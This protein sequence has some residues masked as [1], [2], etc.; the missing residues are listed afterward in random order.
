MPVTLTESAAVLEA[1]GTGKPGRM[2]IRLIDAGKGSSGVYPADTLKAAAE[3]KVFAAGTHMYL[4]HPSESEMYDRPERSVKDLAGV[5]TEDA[6]WDDTAQA[7]VAEARVFPAWRD[8]LTAMAEDIGVSIRALAETKAGQWDGKPAQVVSR[9]TEALSVDFVTHA[10]RGG[11]VMQI[12]ESARANAAQTGPVAVE[13]TANDRREQLSALVKDA[14]S[15]D[16]TWVW[17][18]DFDDT[19]VWFEVESP[20]GLGIYQQTFTVTDDAATALTGDRV[21]VRVKTTYEPVQA[22][23]STGAPT[24]DPVVDTPAPVDESTTLAATSGTDPTPNVPV[25]PAGQSTITQESQ[26][27]D[28]PQ[29]EEARLRQL[30]ADAGRV[31]ALESERDAAA[32]KAEEAEQRALQAEAATYAR[33]FARNLVTK[34][35]SDLAEASVARIVRDATSQALPLTEAGRLDTDAFTPVV[36]K[37]RAEEETYLAAVA[38]ASGIG[39]VRGVGPTLT[40]ESKD[41]TDDELREALAKL[42]EG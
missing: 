30:E 25:D 1:A 39:S 33:D 34:A 11:K 23:E 9:I 29:I 42:K 28:M 7:L 3:A 16:K 19:T 15:A 20:D 5:L 18:R 32:K 24:V 14:Y 26:E 17:V 41:L 37:S 21:E 38:E 27:D 35:N 31:H 13:A 40:E 8:A 2:L 4:D 36:E 22:T 6:R 10:G 12:I